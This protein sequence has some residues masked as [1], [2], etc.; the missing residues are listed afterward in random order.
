MRVAYLAHMH[1]LLTQAEKVFE[2]AHVDV[3]PVSTFMRDDE[4][5]AAIIEWCD[6]VMFDEAHHE[7]MMSMQLK[8]PVL[9]DRIMIGFT[10]TPDRPDNHIIKF[11]AI[12]CPLTRDEAV[13]RGFLAETDLTTVLDY[14]GLNKVNIVLSLFESFSTEIGQSIVFVR[15]QQEVRDLEQGLRAMGMSAVGIASQRRREV[16]VILKEF[17]AKKIRVLISCKKLSEGVDVKGCCTVVVAKHAKSL[18][19]LNQEIGRGARPDTHLHVWQLFNPFEGGK[20]ATS[21]VTPR[22]HRV[23]HFDGSRWVTAEIVA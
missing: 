8:L 6:V 16:A 20:C 2:G 9:L 7:S 1:H 13:E 22:K 14:S 12:V 4:E 5:L 23:V 3:H 19:H 21:I 11:D 17:D 10:A 15:T 18:T